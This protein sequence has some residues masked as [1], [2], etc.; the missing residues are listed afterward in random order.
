MTV[1]FSAK[2]CLLTYG[3]VLY[4][5]NLLSWFFPVKCEKIVDFGEIDAELVLL[6]VLSGEY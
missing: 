1:K 3:V 4:V 6:P 2:K 5:L